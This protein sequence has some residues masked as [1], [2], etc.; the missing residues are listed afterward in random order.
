MDKLQ[1]VKYFDKLNNIING[2]NNIIKAIDEEKNINNLK[3]IRASMINS[4]D[5]A[6]IFK[7]IIKDICDSD[8]SYNTNDLFNELF[9]GG[10]K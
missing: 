2:S 8:N 3:A 10:K 4:R 1:A 5:L 9:R 7:D 6:I